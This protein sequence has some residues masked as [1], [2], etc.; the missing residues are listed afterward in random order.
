[1]N[2]PWLVFLLVLI[3]QWLSAQ[4]GDL[5]RKK[6]PF[7]EEERDDFTVVVGAMLTLLGLLIGFAFSMAVTRYDLRKNYEEAEANANSTK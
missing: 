7:K 5:V 2:S 1:M 4:A 3:V 6:F